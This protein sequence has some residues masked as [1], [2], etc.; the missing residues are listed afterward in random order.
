M[1]ISDNQLETLLTARSAQALKGLLAQRNM[2]PSLAQASKLQKHINT[3]QQVQRPVRLGIVH[4]YTS[5]LLD[6]WL[7]F[8]A[9]LNQLSL[10]IYHAPYGVTLQEAAASSGLAE[11]SPDI[12]LLLLTKE[13]LH[14]ALQMPAACI[15]LVDKPDIHEQFQLACEST[16]PSIP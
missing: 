7:H 11:H 3:F 9:A 16:G 12:T 4:T 10:D 8:S 5:E 14:P 6:P 2:V 15:K 13:D 1:K